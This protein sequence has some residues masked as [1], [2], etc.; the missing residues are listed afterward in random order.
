MGV[1]C[2]YTADCLAKPGVVFKEVSSDWSICVDVHTY[3]T[4]NIEDVT[5]TNTVCDLLWTDI[6]YV[7]LPTGKQ[8]SSTWG[9]IISSFRSISLKTLT[10]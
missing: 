6:L 8:V 2:C 10:T 4:D 1:W 7:V 3:F 5:I 9:I